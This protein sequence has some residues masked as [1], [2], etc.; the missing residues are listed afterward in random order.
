MRREHH[1]LPLTFPPSIWQ[2]LRGGEGI[3]DYSP[4]NRFSSEAAA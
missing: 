2:G 4:D 3:G 1:V